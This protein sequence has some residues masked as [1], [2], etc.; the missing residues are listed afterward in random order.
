MN[1]GVSPDQDRD[2]FIEEH[3]DFI[4]KAAQ[5]ICKRKLIWGKDDELSIALIAFNNA[6][7]SFKS[8]RGSFGGYAA[9]L[10]KNALIDHFRKSKNTPL[11]IFG[12]EDDTFDYIDNINSM[13]N[14][15]L[16]L[17]NKRRAEEIVQFARE[18]KEYR[19]DFSLLADSSPSHTDTR[20]HLLNIAL[21]CSKNES[22]TNHIK[23]K[24]QLPVKEIIILTNTNRKF[25]EKWRRYL[26]TLILI[27][28][29]DQYP[30]IR[31]YLNIK[32]GETN[33]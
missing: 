29:S 17:A 1:Q 28:V 23:E 9:V 15:Q 19:L 4:Y 7:E 18:L 14:Y 12:S 24:K 22:V 2:A 30:Y 3:K 20:N 10:I 25:I 32:A 27:L 5:R 26:L 21:L 33:E 16:E 11:L 6:C 8:D 13:N 31:S